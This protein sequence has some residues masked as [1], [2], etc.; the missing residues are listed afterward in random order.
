MMQEGAYDKVGR[1]MDWIILA[2]CML[3]NWRKQSHSINYL[4]FISIKT[5]IIS[6]FR[7]KSAVLNINKCNMKMNQS[8]SHLTPF[9]VVL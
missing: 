3:I 4:L 6:L 9:K 1:V 8:M 7:L 2:E 5:V